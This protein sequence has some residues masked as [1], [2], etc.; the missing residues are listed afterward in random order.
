MIFL[1]TFIFY[2]LDTLINNIL[3]IN[4]F[5]FFTSYLVFSLL[6]IVYPLFKYKKNYFIYTLLISLLFC[7]SISSLLINIV[8]FSFIYLFINTYFK[9]RKYNLINALFLSIASFIIYTV[10]IGIILNINYYENLEIL[11]IFL[12]FYKSLLINSIILIITYFI[13]HKKIK[14]S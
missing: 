4:S 6:V 7:Y 8:S 2:F 10:F 12:P 13:I 9:K 11:Y 14:H 3:M 5:S 1:I